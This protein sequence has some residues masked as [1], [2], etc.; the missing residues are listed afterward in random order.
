MGLQSSDFPDLKALSLRERECLRL[1]HQGM[2]SKEIAVALSLSPHT[3]DHHLRHS[4]RK[5]SASDRRSAARRLAASEADDPIVRDWLS[6]TLALVTAAGKVMGE[7]SE[8]SSADD[9]ISRPIQ[10]HSPGAG[11]ISAPLALGRSGNSF[12]GG[13]AGAAAATEAP[14]LQPQIRRPQHDVPGRDGGSGGDR[15]GIE[16]DLERPALRSAS[17]IAGLLSARGQGHQLSLIEKAVLIAAFA[18]CIS[19][20]MQMSMPMLN[21]FLH[22]L[23][24]TGAL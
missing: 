6:Q 19:F 15:A 8:T 4:I 7:L 1:V 10:S 16:R 11:G 5:L 9:P 20:L 13:P 23:H 12:D 2:N 17:Q 3:V 21:A 14:D 24:R 18:L 22:G